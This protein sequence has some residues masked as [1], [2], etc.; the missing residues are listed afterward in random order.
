MDADCSCLFY[1]LLLIL[2]QRGEHQGAHYG[3]YQQSY[4]VKE[5]LTYGGEYEHAA[6]R[7][8]Q[9]AAEGH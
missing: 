8:H 2:L 4:D 1:Y 6:V 5:G 9:R 3:A 7:S